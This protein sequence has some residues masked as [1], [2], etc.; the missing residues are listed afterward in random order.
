MSSAVFAVAGPGADRT[1]MI[2][3][4]T[5]STT[6]IAIDCHRKMVSENG[7]TPV[8]GSS[9]F[10]RLAALACS[11]AADDDRPMAQVAPSPRYAAPAA[12]R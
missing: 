8:I 6:V 2:H 7:I 3:E 10:G 5:T 12:A 11:C 4:M 9:A 1:A